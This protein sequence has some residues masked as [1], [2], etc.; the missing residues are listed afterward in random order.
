MRT[1]LKKIGVAA[2]IVASLNTFNVY[3]A[4]VATGM[5]IYVN[6]VVQNPIV[7][8]YAIDGHTLV[9][10]RTVAEALGAK[11][12]WNQELQRASI[13][14]HSTQLVIEP[15]S[16][17]CKV[18]GVPVQ[19]PRAVEVKSETC[20]VPLRF[21]SEQ[22]HFNVDWIQEGGKIIIEDNFDYQKS[23]E[24][25]RYGHEIRTSDLPAVAEYFPY[26]QK[27]V[28]NWAYQ[29][30]VNAMNNNAWGMYNIMNNDGS[31][32]A[33]LSK[34]A[35]TPIEVNTASYVD[36]NFL[37]TPIKN[38]NGWEKETPKVKNAY[39]AYTQL[40]QF[41]TNSNIESAKKDSLA[42]LNLYLDLF[43]KNSEDYNREDLISEIS[44]YYGHITRHG[45]V[46]EGTFHLMPEAAFRS[47]T[48]VNSV[49]SDNIVLPV[50]VD[51]T[52]KSHNKD[53]INY[54]GSGYVYDY[55][56]QTQN[57]REVGK[58]NFEPGRRISGVVYLDLILDRETG[59]W[60]LNSKTADLAH[61]LDFNI[62]IF[63]SLNPALTYPQQDIGYGFTNAKTYMNFGRISKYEKYISNIIPYLGNNQEL[64]KQKDVSGQDWIY[65][66]QNYEA[67][68]MHWDGQYFNNPYKPTRT[69]AEV[70]QLDAKY[71]P[72]SINDIAENNLV[73]I[74]K[75]HNTDF[76]GAVQLY[77]QGVRYEYEDWLKTLTNERLAEMGFSQNQ[78][79]AVKAGK[80]IFDD[81]TGDYIIK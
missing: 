69:F 33:K 20:M 56:T 24:K 7:E 61:Q 18:D 3:A 42:N 80:Q 28:P 43:N 53:Y 17:I 78:I 34:A 52:I 35:S 9:P 47:V 12:E 4:D 75:I 50:Y 72:Q 60:G 22:L 2:C 81:N 71:G 74:M 66:K 23:Y 63:D 8:P 45:L 55:S 29:S 10:I 40:F 13:E 27:D 15:G 31:D 58:N 39:E 54:P 70:Q 1:F 73:W 46:T 11:V 68:K 25:D 38:Y 65:Y 30:V 62:D 36:Y 41:L 44:A 26:I 37:T 51:F 77:S 32:Y 48:Y 76:K 59:L 64:I 14:L 21:I 57:C 6:G 5:T 49:S 16:D 19:M 79:S 67:N